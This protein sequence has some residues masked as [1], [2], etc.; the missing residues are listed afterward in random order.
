LKSFFSRPV[1]LCGIIRDILRDWKFF[2]GRDPGTLPPRSICFAPLSAD[3]LPCGLAGILS[4]AVVKDVGTVAVV[5]RL[6]RAALAMGGP[7]PSTDPGTPFVPERHLGGAGV[8]TSL[9]ESVL[10]LKADEALAE[11]FFRPDIEETLRARADLLDSVLASEERWI[12]LQAGRFSTADL[13][14]IMSDLVRLKDALWALH[15]DILFTLDGVREF[16]GG[17]NAS[18]SG[19]SFRKIRKILLLFSALDRLE[20]RGRDSAGIQAAFT[21]KDR[22]IL[23]RVLD[24]LKKEGL[25]EE[26]LKRM[27]PGDTRDG[28]IHLSDGTPEN[29]SPF[30]SFTY[31]KASITGKLGENG[32]YL[33]ER[34]RSDRIFRLFLGEPVETETFLIHTR[35]ASVGSITEDNCHP[36]NNYTAGSD[37]RNGPH[38]PVCLPAREFLRYGMGNWTIDVALNGDIDN[39]RDL[40]EAFENRRKE[41]I[42]SRVTTDTKIIPL[43]VEKYLDEGR[44]LKE[45]FRL[46]VNDFEGSHAIALQSNLDPGTAYLALK[47]SGQSLYVGIC[48]DKYLYASEVY[49]LVEATSRFIKMDGERERVPGDPSTRGQIFVLHRDGAGGL[50]GIEAFGYDGHPLQ[51]SEANIGQAEITTRD[52]D[53]KD[54]P[55]YLLKEILEAPLSVRKTLRGRY[56][57][58]GEPGS[59]RVVFNLGGDVLTPRLLEALD[60]KKIRK[61]FVVGQGTAAVAG[62]AIADAFSIYLKGLPL[63]VEARRATDLSGFLLSESLEDTLVIAVTQSGTTTDTNRAVAMARAKGA[64]LIAIVN[65]RQSDITHMAEGVFYTSDGR[66]IEMAVASTKAFYSQVVAGYLLALC[67]ARR[68]GT[69]T[70]GELLAEVTR[71]E[72]IPGLM[73][74]VI[75]IRDEIRL[76][77]WD[78]VKRKRYWAVVGSGPNKAASDEIRIKLSELCYRTISSD[79][80]EDKK[81]IDLSAEPL[82]LVCAAGSPPNVVE[83]I[84]KDV[85]IFKAHAAS[86]IVI[87]DGDED[88]FRAVSDSVISVPRA[89]FPASVILNTLAGHLWGYYAACSIHE[90][91]SFFH[92]FRKR[93]SEKSLELDARNC[94]VYEKIA[95]PEMKALVETWGREF[96][97][98]VDNGFFSCLNVETVTNLSLLFK[99]ASGKLPLEDFWSEFRHKR[100]S[101]SPLDMMDIYIGRAID[102]LA[103]PV[104]AIRHQAKTVT[105]G[106]SRKIAVPRGILF[107]LMK[108]LGFNVESLSSRNGIAARRIQKAVRGI[109]G[110][111]LYQLHQVDKPG[112][113]TTISI[114]K[115]GGISLTMKSRVEKPATLMGTKRII[116]NTGDLYAG[117]GKSDKAAIVIM[118]LLGERGLIGHL[119]LVHVDFRDDMTLPEKRDLLGDKYGKI[120]ELTRE[121]NLPW[122]DSYLEGFSPA[123]LLG[124]G[125]D[126]IV[127]AI[128]ASLVEKGGPS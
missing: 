84:V 27:E 104:D 90:G 68:F 10:A 101:P 60:G 30:L 13:E 113:G 89:A 29:P 19:E 15:R 88:A 66:D 37:T 108:E 128:R 77:A 14:R 9:E 36:V 35:W 98:L 38:G 70:D 18:L 121:Y 105:V 3:T 91:S 41:S 45:A 28:S 65:R 122:E 87:A 43:Q 73:E 17:S 100:V 107:D 78:V 40:R 69:V 124:E 110:Y 126:G 53:R 82:I 31:K 93:L 92:D 127:G 115:R 5:D 75:S 54:Y 21:L 81:H 2:L 57:I 80:I 4:F 58:E 55:H 67:F 111:T 50:R 46:A 74:E 99:Y 44:S 97:R 33:K 24:L 42:S 120:R 52:I 49:G 114:A 118:P 22:T 47:G 1:G 25:Y 16:H 94:S 11:I 112:E 20:V 125:L 95:D 56:R 12:D 34:V 39:Y 59:G 116:A 64:H 96:Y 83:D 109:R 26:F 23:P 6:S 85:A 86:V 32:A 103:R 62:M 7:S 119:L 117:F 79:V 71:L 76:S 61:I 72:D 123:F 51:L 106:T 48:G 63:R 8:L 102:E